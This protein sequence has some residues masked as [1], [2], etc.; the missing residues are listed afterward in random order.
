MGTMTHTFH[1]GA[2]VWVITTATYPA[3]RK[4][5]II[6]VRGN[7]LTTETTITYDVRLEGD[8]G[9]TEIDEGKMSAT[10]NAAT[11]AY[12]ISLGGVAGSPCVLG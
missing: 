4:G 12:F 1:A 8:N 7:E 3:I 9:T 6:Q 10:L 5:Q 2:T 11:E